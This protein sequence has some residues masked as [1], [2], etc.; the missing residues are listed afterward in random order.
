MPNKKINDVKI[1][2]NVKKYIA[3]VNAELLNIRA[4]ATI[5]SGVI[6]IVEKGYELKVIDPDP[7]NNFYK[8]DSGVNGVE[9]YVIEDF[10]TI[11]EV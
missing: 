9:G 3:I 5:N 6:S 2:E 1:K 7:I 11:L 4:E 8:V 10:V